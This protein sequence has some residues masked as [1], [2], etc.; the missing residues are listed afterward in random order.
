[1]RTPFSP[2]G[3]R[4]RWVTVY[5][6]LVE[7]RTGD[8]VTYAQ[9]S[10]WLGY[11]VREDRSPY[12][13]AKKKLLELDHRTLKNKQGIGYEIVDAESHVGISR[14]H[15]RKAAKQL[16][17]ARGVLDNTDLN[18]VSPATREVI[19][20]TSQKLGAVQ[21]MVR[22]LTRRQQKTEEA[23]KQVRR[24]TKADVAGLDDRLS[25]LEKAL[26][27]TAIPEQLEQ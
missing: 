1:M 20:A 4:A 24:E 14:D 27:G 22:S 9:L 3:D 23:L 8:V 17:K 10:E 18:D 21:T 7:L 16:V 13:Q 2:N 19:V 6:Q 25:R 15:S 26:R 12:Y 11:D 5:E